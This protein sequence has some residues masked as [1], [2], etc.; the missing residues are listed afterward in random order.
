MKLLK[1]KVL[2][3]CSIIGCSNSTENSKISTLPSFTESPAFLPNLH[4]DNT[5]NVFIS[6]V[7]TIDDTST[8]FYSKF[9]A[10]NW[11][12]KQKIASSNN[13]FVNWADFPSVI[14]RNGEIMAAHWLNKVDGGTYAYNVNIATNTDNWN[15]VITPHNDLTATEHGFVSLT[16]LSDSTFASI[17]LDGRNTQNTNS[18]DSHSNT[19]ISNAMT[20]RA[21][22][23]KNDLTILDSYLLDAS[24]CDCCGTSITPT[25]N[26]FIA[27]YR[28]RTS[29]EIRDIS[30]I[31]FE[32]GKWLEPTIVHND[33]W[34]IAA[35][36][37]NGPK[38]ASY[39][40]NVAI[41]WFTGANDTPKVKLAL[42]TNNGT[43][44]GTPISVDYGDPI[45]RVD[46]EF[47]E[48]SV[49]VSWLE[50]AENNRSNTQLKVKEFNLQ[51][52]LLNEF[53]ISTISASRKSGFPQITKYQN[54]IV[55]AW[56]DISDDEPSIYTAILDN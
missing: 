12:P 32:N 31:K 53:H 3:L 56:T 48:N 28:N 37:V 51:G 55:L 17:W 41:A 33:N 30:I 9:D 34:K 47:L 13:W 50:R 36:P 7:E 43:N 42:S 4:T 24:V 1:L 10:K 19:D 40:N 14:A 46:V 22:V 38:L 6:W 45:G 2:I 27:A 5:G 21:A 54:S 23:I 26:G 39:N 29:D 8:L 16:P 35:C 15:K 18:Q 25:Q 20:L 11:L 44:F 52:K 49:Y